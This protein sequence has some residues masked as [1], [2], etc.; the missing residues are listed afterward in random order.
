MDKPTEKKKEPELLSNE[1][2]PIVDKRI[3]DVEAEH[4][5]DERRPRAGSLSSDVSSSSLSSRTSKVSSSSSSSSTTSSAS[6]EVKAWISDSDGR[7]HELSGDELEQLRQG[8]RRRAHLIEE[9]ILR[10]EREQRHLQEISAAGTSSG[11]EWLSHEPTSS[12]DHRSATD[13]SDERYS[14][15]SDEKL[16]HLRHKRHHHDKHPFAEQKEHLHA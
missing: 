4:A 1:E 9:D 2:I 8:R 5:D 13:S 7:M 3:H 14:V 11:H 10:Y 16:H 12:D 6:S 15:R